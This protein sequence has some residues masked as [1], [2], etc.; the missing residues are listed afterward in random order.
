MRPVC[1]RCK[2]EMENEKNGVLVVEPSYNGNIH[3]IWLADLKRC[4]KCEHEIITGF[5][6]T[7]LG[8]GPETLANLKAKY[9]DEYIFLL[10]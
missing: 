7:P 10:E 6:A 4:P 3:K 5:G 1:V 9:D 2:M 8:Y